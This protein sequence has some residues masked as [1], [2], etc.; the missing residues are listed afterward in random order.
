MLTWIHF[1][2]IYIITWNVATGF[3][4]EN[5]LDLL[6]LKRFQNKNSL[7]DFY[8]I[9]LVFI[10]EQMN[11]KCLCFIPKLLLMSPVIL[12]LYISVFIFNFFQL[13]HHFP[14][15]LSSTLVFD[16]KRRV[17]NK[18]II[19]FMLF[20]TSRVPI[21]HSFSVQIY[22]LHTFSTFSCSEEE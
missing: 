22:Y 11:I 6:D 10:F 19:C 21:F 15:T 20:R 1:S 8:I 13:V 7:P 16:E 5:L 14:F 4:E 12:L 17:K 18:I 2:R 3:P 9:G